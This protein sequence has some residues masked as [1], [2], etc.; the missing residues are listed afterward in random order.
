[1]RE[2]S[3]QSESSMNRK[4]FLETC[5]IASL[6][7]T[8]RP[9]MASGRKPRIL[10]RSSWQTI[11][12][13]DIVH[14]PGVLAILEKHLPEAEV[15]LWAS[16]VGH[17]VREMLLR[18]FPNL[19]ITTAGGSRKTLD[20]E[21]EAHALFS[22]IDFFLHGS[23]PWLVARRH[24]E[25]W[26]GM[27]GKPFGVYGI[28]LPESH[29]D[30]PIVSLLSQASFVFFRDSVSLELAKRRGVTAPVME[31]GP[32]GAFAFDIRNDEAALTFLQER[33][34]EEGKFLCVI[35]RYRRTPDWEIPGREKPESEW[36]L[37]HE[38]NQ[39]MAE[40]DLLPYREA[41]IAVVRQ[42]PMKVLIC[43]EDV[44]QIRL[45]KEF[46]Y[47]R[48]P[49]DVKKGVVWRDDFWLPD[50]ALSIYVRSAGLFGL[51]QHSP[52]M[53]IGNGVP[54]FVGRFKEQTSKGFMWKDIGLSEW[55]FDSDTTFDMEQ[56]VPMVLQLAKRPEEARTKA[57]AAKAIVERRQVQTMK[58]LRN[59]LQL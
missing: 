11:N 42:T 12:I 58:V 33:N 25:Q 59:G 52:I 56:L 48:L 36:R 24:V 18:R 51:E 10:L 8:V 27:T 29:A 47:D 13:G 15:I 45:G 32:D 35:P 9:A 16:D 34:L 26:I 55:Y 22:E 28:S 40:R 2:E 5:L 46:L 14:S 1:M 7:A 31:F 39:R 6:L 4:R 21:S 20:Q 44:T 50:E 54:A 38:R 17:G 23:G 3:L 49:D 41:I 43:S 53:C 19:Q 57:L 30:E 37:L